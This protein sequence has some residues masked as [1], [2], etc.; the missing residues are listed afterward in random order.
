MAGW[1]D[2]LLYAPLA[3]E[4]RWLG[5]GR[6]LPAGQSIILIGEKMAAQ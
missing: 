3:A 6:S 1:L 5:G 4:A 2:R